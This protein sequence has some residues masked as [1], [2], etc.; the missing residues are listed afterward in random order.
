ERK[1]KTFTTLITDMGDFYQMCIYFK[2]GNKR[3]VKAE[4]KDSLKIL[5]FSVEKI[6]KDFGL[7]LQK[8]TLD[9]DTP[10]EKGHILTPYEIKYIKHDVIIMSKAIAIILERELTKLTIDSNAINDFKERLKN[11]NSYFP[12]LG[13]IHK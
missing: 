2:V 10:R 11:F 5:N 9:Y 8:L 1:D 13:Y 4:F 3:V 12:N 6:A 7:D